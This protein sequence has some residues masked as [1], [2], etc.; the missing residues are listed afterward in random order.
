M[1]WTS[2]KRE[3]SKKEHGAGQ[4]TCSE[5][6]REPRGKVSPKNGDQRVMEAWI[7]PSA[8]FRAIT[9]VRNYL[10]VKHLE[11]SRH[12]VPDRPAAVAS[13]KTPKYLGRLN[14]KAFQAQF[15][16]LAV[17]EGW[18]RESKA[19]CLTEDAQT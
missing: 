14:W 19:L 5:C 15:D 3:E 6:L 4:R 17:A 8:V 9:L 11:V 13:V 12:V 1:S 2:V 10:P 16:V 18:S 7:T